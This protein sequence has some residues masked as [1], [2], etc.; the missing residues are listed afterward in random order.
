MQNHPRAS[1][2]TPSE[3]TEASMANHPRTVGQ[4]LSKRYPGSIRLNPVRGRML[5]R[6]EGVSKPESR[7]VIFHA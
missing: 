5:K 3:R 7:P 4:S 6:P 1:F 2:A